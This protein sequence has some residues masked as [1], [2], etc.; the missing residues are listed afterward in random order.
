METCKRPKVQGIL[1]IEIRKLE[2]E[3]SNLRASD[4]STAEKGPKK[5]VAA[6]TKRFVTEIN[7]Y[8][9]DQSD[10]FIKIF[11][12]LNGVH[13]IAEENVNVKF[14]ER[15]LSVL[16]S[17]LE[18]K[19]HKLSILNLLNEINC[20]KSYSKVKTD[21]IAIYMKKAKENVKWGFVTVTE[22]R[23]SDVKNSALADEKPDDGNPNAALMNLM[24]KMYESGDPTTKQMIEKAYTENMHKTVPEF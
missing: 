8:G 6:S 17:D 15:N 2:T 7:N 4:D 11:I 12:T 21:M 22:K 5:P 14:E 10:K 9:W 23:V 16:V 24:K 18:G 19:D 3:I 13:T 20:E 1:S